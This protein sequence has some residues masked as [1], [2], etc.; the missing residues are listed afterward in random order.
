MKNLDEIQKTLREQKPYLTEKFGV[1]VL[2]VFGSYVHQE[3]RSDSDLDLLIEL[4]R[5]PRI[6]LIGLVEVE[7]YLSQLLGVKVDLA[8]KKNLKKRIGV[9]ILQEVIPL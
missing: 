2:G 8:I 3:Q 1:R 6:S 7:E 5:P 9:R 4:D